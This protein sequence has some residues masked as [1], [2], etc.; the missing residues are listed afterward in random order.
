MNHPITP[1]I[2]VL[3]EKKVEFEPHVFEYL[4]KGGTKHSPEV[5]GIDE[6]SVIKSLVFETNEKKPFIV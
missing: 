3:R 5:L 1:A 4:E 6:H 2:R